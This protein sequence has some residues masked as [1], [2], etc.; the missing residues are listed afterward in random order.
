MVF[1]KKG[2]RDLHRVDPPWSARATA[3]GTP[4][5]HRALDL[6]PHPD[7]LIQLLAQVGDGDVASLLL[8]L[9]KGEQQHGY[10]L[11][12]FIEKNLSRFNTL[13]K[14]SAPRASR[15]WRSARHGALN[16]S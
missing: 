1:V 2:R 7:S 6:Y 11:N 10:Q 5:S 4:L 12:D 3:S 8:G 9:L 13:K 15:S 16:T 14:A